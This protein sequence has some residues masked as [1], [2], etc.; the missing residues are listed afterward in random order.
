M[1]CADFNGT[2]NLSLAA[3]ADKP[4]ETRCWVLHLQNVGREG[5]IAA[6]R[7]AGPERQQCEAEQIGLLEEITSAAAVSA[8]RLSS[9]IGW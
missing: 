9:L 1:T 7:C 4:E 2:T 5:R 6:V 3:H 8:G